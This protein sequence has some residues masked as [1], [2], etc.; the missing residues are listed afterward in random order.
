MKKIILIFCPWWQRPEVT[1][2]HLE[3][4][5]KCKKSKYFELKYLAVISPEDPF[6]KELVDLAFEFNCKIVTYANLPL[7]AKHNAGIN[8]AIREIGWDYIMNIGSDDKLFPILF[9]EY[10]KPVENGELFFGIMNFYLL[11]YYTGEQLHFDRGI[12]LHDY[13]I[14]G[15]RMIHR[16][17]IQKF[18]DAY[19]NLYDNNINKSLDTSSQQNIIKMGYQLHKIDNKKLKMIEAVKCDL[20]INHWAAFKIHPNIRQISTNK[21]PKKVTKVV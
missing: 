9:K 12:E 13:V 17:I 3:S 15:C 16:S 4:I 14:G 1:R 6:F 11:N 19:I 8:F 18:M 21:T 7:G 10:Q 20:S 2:L 5:E